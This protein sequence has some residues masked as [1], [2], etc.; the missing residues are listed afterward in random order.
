MSYNQPA[1]SD[2]AVDVRPADR[3]AAPMPMP[4]SQT[5]QTA[6]A[7]DPAGAAGAERDREVPWAQLESLHREIEVGVCT[8]GSECE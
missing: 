4:M 1:R 2:Q 5:A 7:S 8:A 6:R 3:S